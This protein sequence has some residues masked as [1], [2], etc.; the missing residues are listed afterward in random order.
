ME[1]RE[2]QNIKNVVHL[3]L[4]W[5]MFHLKMGHI[6]GKYALSGVMEHVQL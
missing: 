3:M 5:I 4:P 1:E 6:Y 2:N